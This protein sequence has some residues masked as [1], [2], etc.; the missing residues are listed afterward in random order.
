MDGLTLQ[1]LDQLRRWLENEK[2]KALQA[3]NSAVH[4]ARWRALNDVALRLD[5]M[6]ADVVT[7]TLVDYQEAA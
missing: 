6:L 1:Q 5:E 4:A 7:V 3:R 2:T